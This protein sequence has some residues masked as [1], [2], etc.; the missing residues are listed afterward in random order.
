VHWAQTTIGNL[1][2]ASVA[3]NDGHISSHKESNVVLGMNPQT[4]SLIDVVA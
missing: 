4:F 3:F 1:R 2:I